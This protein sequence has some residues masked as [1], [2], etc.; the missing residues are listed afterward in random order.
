MHA[1][2]KRGRKP[3]IKAGQALVLPSNI[4]TTV[5]TNTATIVPSNVGSNKRRAKGQPSSNPK[6]KTKN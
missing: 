1:N 3:K 2:K 5:P 6:K 4:E